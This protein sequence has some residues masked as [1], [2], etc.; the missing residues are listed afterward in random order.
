M[1]LSWLEATRHDGAGAAMATAAATAPVVA[2]PLQRLRRRCIASCRIVFDSVAE[3]VSAAR[4]AAAVTARGGSSID[5]SQ[6]SSS[7]MRGPIK[8]VAPRRFG[9]LVSALQCAPLGKSKAKSPGYFTESRIG[10][11]QA[12]TPQHATQKSPAWM[13]AKKTKRVLRAARSGSPSRAAGYGWQ[14]A[15]RTRQ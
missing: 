3:L 14:I 1:L 8:S 12:G 13:A 4:A 7:A 9:R 11:R 10:R 5:F 6:E 15:A 2:S